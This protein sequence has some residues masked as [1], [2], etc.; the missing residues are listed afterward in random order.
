MI[1]TNTVSDMREGAVEVR[2]QGTSL[3]V[4]MAGA[5]GDRRAAGPPAARSM[6]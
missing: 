1:S 6:R 5:R 4:S 3:H 2:S